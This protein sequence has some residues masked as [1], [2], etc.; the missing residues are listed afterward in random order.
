MTGG[1][2]ERDP[3][4][5]KVAPIWYQEPIYYKCNRFSVVGSGADIVKPSYCEVLDYELEFGGLLGKGGKN[6][7]KDDARRHIFGYCIFNDVSA[8]DQ[9]VREMRGNLG[10][11]RARISIPG[12][13]SGH[14]S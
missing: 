8:R 6:I 7:G 2:A 9:Q 11:R 14:G 10:R 13:C 3:E 12:T 4:K 5:I 1:Y